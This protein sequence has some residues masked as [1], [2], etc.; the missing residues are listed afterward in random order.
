MADNNKIYQKKSDKNFKM[1]KLITLWQTNI[2]LML[3]A[4]SQ[5]MFNDMTAANL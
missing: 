5:Y 4:F 1:R 2:F 3:P